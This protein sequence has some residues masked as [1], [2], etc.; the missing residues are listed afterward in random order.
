MTVPI[1]ATARDCRLSAVRCS[2]SPKL[3]SDQ[4]IVRSDLAHKTFEQNTL[5]AF[6]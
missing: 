4:H 3:Q 5:V 6:D 2:K 1:S